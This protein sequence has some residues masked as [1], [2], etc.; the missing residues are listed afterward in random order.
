VLSDIYAERNINGFVL[1]VIVLNV[2][3]LSVVAPVLLVKPSIIRH[4]KGFVNIMI[5]WG[6]THN[7]SFSS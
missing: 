2:V 7:T 4:F 3:V 6:H 5:I 1:S